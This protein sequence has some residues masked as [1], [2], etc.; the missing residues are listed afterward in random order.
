MAASLVCVLCCLLKIGRCSMVC[1][2]STSCSR[3]RCPS[4]TTASLLA[5]IVVSN[6]VGHPCMPTPTIV[7]PLHQDI[8]T[9]CPH[10]YIMPIDAASRPTQQAG[11]M[12]RLSPSTNLSASRPPQLMSASRVTCHRQLWPALMSIPRDFFSML[13]AFCQLVTGQTA[14]RTH[15]VCAAHRTGTGDT[16][17]CMQDIPRHTPPLTHLNLHLVHPLLQ[18]CACSFSRRPCAT[19]R[20]SRPVAMPLL[21]SLSARSRVSSKS[22]FISSWPY[23]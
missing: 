4:T 3:L 21:T 7:L 8:V 9:A 5:T 22:D 10:T 13:P 2:S 6:A 1:S 19:S 14:S 11:V 16:A 23:T 20:R 15:I 17:R 12:R 18:W